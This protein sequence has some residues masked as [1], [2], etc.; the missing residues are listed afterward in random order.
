MPLNVVP[1][2]CGGVWLLGQT[3]TAP[4]PSLPVRQCVRSPASCWAKPSMPSVEC[5]PVPAPKRERGLKWP[6]A[7][8]W[9]RTVGLILRHGSTVARPS[10]WAELRKWAGRHVALCHWSPRAPITDGPVTPAQA[11]GQPRLQSEREEKGGRQAAIFFDEKK[12]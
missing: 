11:S 2:D 5:R 10:V 4:L 12:E 9:A 7:V 3:L 6:A 8:Q 1:E